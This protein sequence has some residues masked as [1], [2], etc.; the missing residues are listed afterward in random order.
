MWFFHHSESKWSVLSYRV[1]WV[2][3]E[4]FHIN[5]IFYWPFSY[6]L[7]CNMVTFYLLLTFLNIFTC[8]N[9]ILFELICPPQSMRRLHFFHLDTSPSHSQYSYYPSRCF[10]FAYAHDEVIAQESRLNLYLQTA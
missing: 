7:I 8:I 5:I 6:I 2:S 9:Q 1:S 4:S 10:W 3:T